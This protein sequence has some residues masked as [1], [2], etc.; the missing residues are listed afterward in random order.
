MLNDPKYNT[1]RKM[2]TE[3]QHSNMTP[4]LKIHSIPFCFQANNHKKCSPPDS[5]NSDLDQPL[6]TKYTQI[7][8]VINAVK[9]VLQ[10]S[11]QDIYQ[12]SLKCAPRKQNYP[13]L[14]PAEILQNKGLH[15]RIGVQWGK[16]TLC[17]SYNHPVL[18]FSLFETQLFSPIAQEA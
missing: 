13:V 12:W 14:C 11:L 6:L 17:L 16:P 15:Q 9:M 3:L 10:H 4:L 18:W 7:K 2:E 1:K 5:L 8:P